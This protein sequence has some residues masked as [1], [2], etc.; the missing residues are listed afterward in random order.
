MED[1]D[2]ASV[3]V[4]CTVVDDGGVVVVV[5]EV[6][7]VA[8]L[9]GSDVDVFSSTRITN[10]FKKINTPSRDPADQLV[11]MSLSTVV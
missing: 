3:D 5:C 1:V 4:S 7:P 9:N 2:I 10:I 6:A 11:V 8:A